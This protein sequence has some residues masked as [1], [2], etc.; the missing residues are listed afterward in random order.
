MG[1]NSIHEK[2]YSRLL[3]STRFLF[4]VHRS[5]WKCYR[6]IDINAADRLPNF[7]T[8]C[9]FEQQI[10]RLR[11]LARSYDKTTCWTLKQGPEVYKMLVQRNRCLLKR[12]NTFLIEWKFHHKQICCTTSIQWTCLR[13]MAKT[14]IMD[15]NCKSD[16]IIM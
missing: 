12:S 1:P 6:G 15:S 10:S 3:E 8:I 2:T 9:T 16:S 7:E 4:V 5:L 11:D 14:I 13:Y